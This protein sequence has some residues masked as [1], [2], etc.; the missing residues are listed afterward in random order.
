MLS[1][2]CFGFAF[3]LHAL[4]RAIQRGRG[5]EVNSSQLRQRPHAEREL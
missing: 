1:K 2:A 4:L 5:H 3:K